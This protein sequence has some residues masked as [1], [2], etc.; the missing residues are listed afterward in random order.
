[1]DWE[2][3]EVIRRLMDQPGTVYQDSDATQRQIFRDWLREL[4]HKDQVTI[5][6]VKADGAS[7]TMRC[8]LNWD[9]IPKEKHPK[10]LRESRASDQEP[11]TLAVFDLDQSEWRS[12]K[13][14]RVRQISATLNLE[15]KNIV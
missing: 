3:Q 4:L 5:T 8:T 14:E 15:P 6:F 10:G 2:R 11:S 12:F 13:Y 9:H 7:R 1:M